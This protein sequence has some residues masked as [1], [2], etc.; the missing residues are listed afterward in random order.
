MIISG[1]GMPAPATKEGPAWPFQ[2]AAYFSGFPHDDHA[3]AASSGL[4]LWSII[5]NI[6]L[7]TT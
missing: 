7:C 1:A 3:G 4:R 5:L 2:L 6:L